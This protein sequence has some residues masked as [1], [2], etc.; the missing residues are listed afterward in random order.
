MPKVCCASFSKQD[1]IDEGKSR[2]NLHEAKFLSALCRYFI[3]QGYK[4]EQ[5]TILTAY[6]G[7]LI[8]L[9]REMPKDFFQGVRVCAV[10]NFQGEENDIILLSLVRS[11]EEGKIGF[12]QI[13][14]RVCVALSRAKKGFYCIGNMSLLKERS[15]LWEK[16]IS[17]M[18]K[19]GK[20][21]ETLTLTCQNHPTNV[22][23][24]S[25]AEDFKKA[26]EGGCTEPC[27]TRLKCGHVC[28]MVCHPTDPDHVKYKCKKP[29]TK[30][31]CS[32]NHR[33]HK[34]CYQDCGPC[35]KLVEKTIP[36][37]GHVA[38]VPCSVSESEAKCMSPCKQTLSCGH[39]CI[40][41]C[42]EECTK[43][44]VAPVKKSWPCGHENEVKCHVNPIFSPCQATCGV[45]LKCEH[46][47]EGMF[48]F[49]VSLC[50]PTILKLTNIVW[51]N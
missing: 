48:V 6:T 28:A 24:A 26:P 11:N 10:D 29:C 22:I 49:L 32:Q 42:S 16:I 23:Q 30:T 17:D 40:N 47:C 38:K 7:Q 35:M 3:L 46:L 51:L 41:M 39:P 21:G 31:L 44:C 5:I 2:S 43:V 37:C 25:R 15:A 20:I 36:R 1:Y 45:T 13:E 8:Q 14:N 50:L 9:K 12:L 19:Q 18:R 27:S 34:Q 33:C 4:R